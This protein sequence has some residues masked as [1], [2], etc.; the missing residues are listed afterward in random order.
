MVA[1]PARTGRV[2]EPDGVPRDVLRDDDLPHELLDLED[3]GAAEH[4]L[5]HLA[6]GSPVVCVHDAGPL[7]PRA[8]RS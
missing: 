8:G 7:R 3:L 2:D 1:L 5:R 6:V 4:A